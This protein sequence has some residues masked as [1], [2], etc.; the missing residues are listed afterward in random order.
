M[1]FL[2]AL[3]VKTVPVCSGSFLR[4]SFILGWVQECGMDRLRVTPLVSLAM[5]IVWLAVVRCQETKHN[6]EKLFSDCSRIL[7]GCVTQE[8]AVRGG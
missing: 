1:C 5:S 2:Q 4:L 3:R 6:G 8:A 7:G